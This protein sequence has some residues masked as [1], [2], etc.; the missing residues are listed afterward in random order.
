MWHGYFGLED[1]NLTAPQ[2]QTLRDA[3]RQFFADNQVPTGQPAQI[4]QI[5]MSLN[6]R[7]VIFEA[8]FDEQFLTVDRFKTFL[9]NTFGVAVGQIANV[10]S[11]LDLGGKDS[12]LITFSRSGTN[13]IRVVL[14]GGVGA[15]YEESRVACLAYLNSA[16]AEW[17]PTP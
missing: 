1:L 4:L 5:R 7:K 9:A 6:G 8:L 12:P 2:R 3:I 16:R 14:F 11:T 13:Y 10:N 17:D 15:S